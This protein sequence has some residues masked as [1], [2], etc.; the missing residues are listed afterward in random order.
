VIARAYFDISRFVYS[1]HVVSYSMNELYDCIH[2]AYCLLEIIARKPIGRDRLSDKD[3]DVPK[4]RLLLNKF[5]QMTQ[6]FEFD[7]LQGALRFSALLFTYMHWK[8]HGWTLPLA[9]C[10]LYVALER[11]AQGQGK[12]RSPRT[13]YLHSCRTAHRRWP[14]SLQDCVES[15]VLKRTW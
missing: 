9:R 8:Q 12:R 4:N 3:I 14:V 5:R 2:L 1:P 7:S 6:S 10:P 11:A 13:S 15:T